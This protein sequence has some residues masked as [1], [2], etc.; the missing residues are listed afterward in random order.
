MSMGWLAEEGAGESHEWDTVSIG[1]EHTVEDRTQF[2]LQGAHFVEELDKETGG[3][4]IW[5]SLSVFRILADDY[6]ITHVDPG[7]SQGLPLSTFHSLNFTFWAQQF[8][9]M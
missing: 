1:P 6:V 8:Q 4:H 3:Y 2:C 5:F 7:I 9:W